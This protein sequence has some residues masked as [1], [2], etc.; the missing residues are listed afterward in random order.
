MPTMP[1]RACARRKPRRHGRDA[2]A[3]EAEPVDHAFVCVQAKQPRT[4]IAR[5]RLRRHPADFDEAEAEAE[6][7]IRHLGILV[8]ARRKADRIGKRQAERLHAQLLVVARGA[9]QRRHLERIERQRVRA[10]RIE[11]AQ[12]RRGKAV[13]QS[14]HASSSGNSCPPGP[15]GNG[16]TQRTADNGSVP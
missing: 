3:V 1:R 2:L 8:E 4:R 9:R 7:L 6:E 14:D 5:L 16:L 11:R 12:Q 15:S 10:L 13:E